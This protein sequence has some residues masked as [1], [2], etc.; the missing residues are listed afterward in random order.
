M[1]TRR[2][3]ASSSAKEW[4]LPTVTVTFWFALRQESSPL[5]VHSQEA[6]KDHIVAYIDALMLNLSSSVVKIPEGGWR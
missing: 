1:V 5:A 6:L 3:A 4:L 2:S